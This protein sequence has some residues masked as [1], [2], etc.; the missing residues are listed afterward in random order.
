MLRTRGM[1][2]GLTMIAVALAACGEESPAGQETTEGSPVAPATE[3]DTE[4]ATDAS[5]GLDTDVE[6][7]LV[8]GTTAASSA[9]YAYAVTT[10]QEIGQLLPNVEFNVIETAGTT[11]NIHRMVNGEIELLNLV[12]S[13]GYAAYNGTAEFDEPADVR[14]LWFFQEY[15]FH[16]IVSKDTGI[17][18]LDGL[19]DVT[20]NPGINGSS[21]EATV[22]RAFEI[23]GVEPDLY[24]G[25][26]DDAVGAFKDRRIDGLTKAGPIPEPVI[27][28][29]RTAV[30]VNLVSFTSEELDQV[31]EEVPQYGRTT[32][33]AGTYEGIEHDVE[34]LSL[35][36]GIGAA[37]SVSDDVAYAIT[38]ANAEAQESIASAHAS[39][40]GVDLGEMTLRA[41][42]SPLHCGAIRYYEEIGHAIP[43]E[44][45]PSECP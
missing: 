25:G 37:A 38:R 43:D 28:D 36:L 7:D 14:V 23:L 29:L 15:P 3:G 4:A 6:A 9:N 27:S 17:E 41:A 5:D 20:F 8:W 44:L 16:I 26:L 39:L 34:T 24:R 35:Y 2:L 33:P 21:T 11:D 42:K 45:R 1:I 31:Q 30:D 19:N 32:I 18:S 10:A 40:A 12:A 22:L 13:A